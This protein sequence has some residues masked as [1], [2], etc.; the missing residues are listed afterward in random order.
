MLV[1]FC[2]DDWIIWAVSCFQGLKD[3]HLYAVKWPVMRVHSTALIP[4][5]AGRQRTDWEGILHF[6]FSRVHRGAT[7]DVK[8]VSLPLQPHISYTC[9]HTSLV[10]L[11]PNDSE[12]CAPINIV[13]E[14]DYKG[15][16]YS[17]RFRWFFFY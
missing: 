13:G 1:I 7:S 6:C 2:I 15:N 12:W 16:F 8:L 14:Q 10:S 17:R 11:P 5:L 3:L 4:P 9:D